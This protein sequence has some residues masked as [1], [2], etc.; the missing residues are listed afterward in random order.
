VSCSFK[1][2][3]RCGP[4]A[5]SIYTF[6]IADPL[7]DSPP[8]WVEA[9]RL[10][11]LTLGVAFFPQIDVPRATFKSE[12]EPPLPWQQGFGHVVFAEILLAQSPEGALLLRE[13]VAFPTAMTLAVVAQLRRPLTDGPGTRGHNHPTFSASSPDGDPGTGFVPFGLRFSDGSSLDNL[14]QRGS[15]DRLLSIR[16]SGGSRRGEQEFATAIPPEGEVEVWV[17]WPAAGITEVSTTLD[18]APIRRAAIEPGLW[19]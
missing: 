11:D 2:L 6:D 13:L 12:D 7:Q 3:Q 14:S 10:I 9:G 18:A 4:R 19:F 1:A 17:A 5:T 15:R 16:G 8:L